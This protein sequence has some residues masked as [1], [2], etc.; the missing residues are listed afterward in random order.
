MSTEVD[1]S[2]RHSAQAGPSFLVIKT[3]MNLDAGLRR[4]D[5]LSLS[6]KAKDSRTLSR[7]FGREFRRFRRAFAF[8]HFGEVKNHWE[9][10]PF[11]SPQGLAH[12][13]RYE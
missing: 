13:L 5:E 1:F 8:F 4:H 11:C 7:P 10:L 2:L 6:L 9:I 12:N 3:T